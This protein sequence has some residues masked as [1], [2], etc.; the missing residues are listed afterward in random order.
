MD[1]QSI[2]LQTKV[3]TKDFFKME[4]GQALEF[5]NTAMVIGTKDNG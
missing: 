4:Q 5:S 1:K 3:G 2:F